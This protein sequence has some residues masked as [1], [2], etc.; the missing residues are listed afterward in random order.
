[1]FAIFDCLSCEIKGKK[2][3]W[4]IKNTNKKNGYFLMENVSVTNQTFGWRKKCF[5]NGLNV[6]VQEK[7]QIEI[8]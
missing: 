6:K 3:K 2:K 7:W 4:K 8:E 1:M 5:L